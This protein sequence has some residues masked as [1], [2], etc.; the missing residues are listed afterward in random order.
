MGEHQE[1]EEV[2]MV[3]LSGLGK[4]AGNAGKAFLGGLD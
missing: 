3:V 1:E 2:V 4:L